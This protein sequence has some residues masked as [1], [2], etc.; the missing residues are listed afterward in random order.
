MSFNVHP[1]T[2]FNASAQFLDASVSADGLLNSLL[3][4]LSGTGGMAGADKLGGAFAGQYDKAARAAATGLAKVDVHLGQI[5]AGLLAT[6]TNYWR[7]DAGSNMQFPINT[8]TA[9]IQRANQ[10]ERVR[11]YREE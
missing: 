10:C 5:A 8:S 7:A 1:D 3:G 2:L 11:S 4:G 6:A 9:P